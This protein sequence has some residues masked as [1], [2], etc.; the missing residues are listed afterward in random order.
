VFLDFLFLSRNWDADAT[1]IQ[2]VF[3]RLKNSTFPLWIISFSEGTRITPVKSE[4]SRKYAESVGLSPT[5]Y[6]MVPRTKGFVA[7]ISAM[8]SRVDAVYDVTIAYPEGVPTTTQLLKGY[9]SEIHLHV[10]RHSIQSLPEDPGALS[11][12]LLDRFQEKDRWLKQYYE[13]RLV[14]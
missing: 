8:R 12:W 3:S 1:L 7:T 9:V 13:N 10:R 5:D 2:K 6:V 4:A 14:Q 11:A